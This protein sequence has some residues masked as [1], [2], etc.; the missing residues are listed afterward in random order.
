MRM[1]AV[2][3]VV[4]LVAVLGAFSVQAVTLQPGDLIVT[5]PL[6]SSQQPFPP[7]SFT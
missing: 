4:A 1:L 3:A 2:S 7:R 5:R 6:S